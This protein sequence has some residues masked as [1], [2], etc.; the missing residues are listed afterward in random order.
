[1]SATSLAH[2]ACNLDRI[3]DVV[4]KSLPRIVFDEVRKAPMRGLCEAQIGT[5]VFYVSEKGDFLF[6]GNMVAVKSGDNLTQQR[7]TGI[8]KKVIADQDEANMLVIG[9]DN[10]K[11][12][13]TVFTDV[14][15]PYCSK[16]H[17]EVPTLNRHGV[18][19]RYLLYP[20]NGT[21]SPTYRKS[22][23]V[24][25]ADDRVK[26]IGVAKA[27]GVVPARNCDNPVADHYRLG[28]RLNITGTPTMI[29]EDGT[30][31]GGYVPAARL[32]AAL[33]LSAAADNPASK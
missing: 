22:V 2:A 28:V 31:V 17:E 14:D 18:K 21:T 29:L 5:E 26:A 1:L 4:S 19:I 20:R 9:P 16:L 8:V 13:V 3:N 6:I 11:A 12:T 30:K 27:G 23:S 15:C 10:V 7:R 33:G 24:W 32:L 25:C